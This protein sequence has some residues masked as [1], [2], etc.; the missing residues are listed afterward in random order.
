MS[1]TTAKGG[2]ADAALQQDRQI[3]SQLEADG[4]AVWAPVPGLF[5]TVLAIFQ[6]Q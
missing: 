5:G 3:S 2:Q 4:D 6:R 1:P